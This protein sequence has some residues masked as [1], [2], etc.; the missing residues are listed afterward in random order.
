M[1]LLMGN[2]RLFVGGLPPDVRLVMSDLQPGGRFKVSSP[3]ALSSRFVQ[4]GMPFPMSGEGFWD[5]VGQ[6]V[7]FTVGGTP[8][9]APS[10]PVV[11]VFAGLQVAPTLVADPAEDQVWTLVGEFRH[12][13]TAVPPQLPVAIPDESARRSVFGWYAQITQVI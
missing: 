8:P 1:P 6:A 7:S 4:G 5:E 9:P 2:W 12:A 3:G 13:L 11:V 10:V